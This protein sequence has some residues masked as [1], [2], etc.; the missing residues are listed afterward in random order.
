MGDQ[1]SFL[2]RVGQGKDALPQVF[3]MSMLGGEARQI[4]RAGRGVQHYA[5]SPNGL[6]IAF[7][8]SDDPANKAEI[9]KGN[10]GFEVGN[11]DMFLAAAPTSSHIW[12]ISSEGGEARR[13]TSGS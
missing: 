8:T 2:A 12:L 10:D 4:T 9:E 6:S 11:N 7:V 1:L 5:W 13:L 3:V